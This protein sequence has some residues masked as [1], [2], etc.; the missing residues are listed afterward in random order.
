MQLTSN[1][2][3]E[4]K[5]LSGQNYHRTST[6]GTRPGVAPS[7]PLVKIE[8]SQQRAAR[9][10]TEIWRCGREDA[11]IAWYE[12]ERNSERVGG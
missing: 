10:I 8:I 2:K 4:H 11:K 1:P 3:Q 5:I 12:N 7:S 6:N 9:F